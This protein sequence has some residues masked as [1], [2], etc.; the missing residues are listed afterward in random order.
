MVPNIISGSADIL[1]LR[2]P[3]L[4]PARVLLT[5]EPIPLMSYPAGYPLCPPGGRLLPEAPVASYR[6]PSKN[7]I[8]SAAEG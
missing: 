1:N 3:L 2:R 6:I 4:L 8:S 5:W 7:V